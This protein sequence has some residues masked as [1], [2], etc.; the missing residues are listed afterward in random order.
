[1]KLILVLALAALSACSQY[2]V[3]Y[4]LLEPVPQTIVTNSLTNVLNYSDSLIDAEF[5]IN[6]QSIAL[7]LKNLSPVPA[8]LKWDDFT[9]ITPENIAHRVIIGETTMA[10]RDQIQPPLLLGPGL[11]VQ[12]SLFPAS[13][14]YYFYDWQV[15]PLISPD[16][17]NYQALVGKS[18]GLHFPLEFDGKST[19]YLFRFKIDSIEK[20]T[21]TNTSYQQQQNY[22]GR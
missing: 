18:I 5:T 9:F 13:F 12:K 22:Q 15:A 16:P 17:T 8:R 11:S 14:I 19:Y 21:N 3:K 7:R 4:S 6:E 2:T 10:N 1:M 20:K